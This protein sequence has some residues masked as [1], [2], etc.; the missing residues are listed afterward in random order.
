MNYFEINLTKYVQLAENYKTLMRETKD[1]SKWRDRLCTQI[2]RLNIVRMSIFLR[3]IYEFAKIL[4]KIPANYFA[5]FNKLILKYIC[6]GP[7]INKT[8]LK[9]K[10]KKQRTHSILSYFNT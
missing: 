9:K 6:K 10:Y 4:V 2:R 3:L 8:I 5:G 1:I 7:R